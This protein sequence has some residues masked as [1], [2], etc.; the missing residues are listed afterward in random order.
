MT[1]HA[2]PGCIQAGKLGKI[3]ATIEFFQKAE[4][5]RE[6]RE[7]RMLSA[8]E[9][10]AAQ[11][12]TLKAYGDTLLRHEKA[13]TEVFTRIKNVENSPLI[14][15]FLNTKAGRYT[16][17]ALIGAAAVGVTKNPEGFG[18]IVKLVIGGP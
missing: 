16:F 15:K 6:Y 8:M 2:E 18:K 4:E 7:E 5:K 12:S 13:F 1:D 10:I 11:G 14:T 9:E 17:A 3:E